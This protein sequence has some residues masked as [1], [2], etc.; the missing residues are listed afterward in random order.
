M[1]IHIHANG[2][3]RWDKPVEV[4][5]E[6]DTPVSN[7]IEIDR[8]GT[9]LDAAV[10]FQHD[11]DGRLVLLLTSITP[12]D[13]TRHYRLAFGPD[14]QRIEP[15]VTLR[16]GVEDEGQES[17]QAITTSAT[18]FYHKLG[19]GFSSLLDRD[20][21]DWLSYHPG[22]GSAGEYRGIPNMGHPEGYCHPG[23]AASHSQVTAGGPLCVRIQS[24]SNDGMMCC[25]WDNFP[26]YARLTVLQMRT[27]YW[28]LYEGTPGGNPGGQLDEAGG[29]C[30]RSDGVRTPLSERWEGP[31]P[32]PEWV[33]FGA[34][35]VAR[36]LY[37]VHHEADA[38]IDSYWPMEHDMTVFG[39]GRLG[40]E[41]FMT[42][43]PARFTVGFVED[44]AFG[45]VQEA[46]DSAFRPL[47]IDLS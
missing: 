35:N 46:I 14:A 9:A 38:E 7:V 15:L 3:Q 10:P 1:D 5:L 44:G 26:G 31:L 11:P 42:Q 29:Y 27:P 40:L 30:V 8:E 28:F 2:F 36:V 39:F 34:S 45:H 18:W 37:L 17:Y 25:R 33:Y 20:G 16:D 13:A 19:A 41:K 24:A 47:S 32:A 21:L 12:A 23:K 4:P 43:V 22:G 6:T